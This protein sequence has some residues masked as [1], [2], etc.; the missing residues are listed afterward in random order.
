MSSKDLFSRP[1][2]QQETAPRSLCPKQ[3]IFPFCHAICRL[4]VAVLSRQCIRFRSALFVFYSRSQTEG[5][6]AT[7]G[8]SSRYGSLRTVWKHCPSQ[9]LCL[10]LV[11]C[12]FCPHSTGQSE[13]SG[14]I[15]RLEGG[16][17][18][19]TLNLSREGRD[20]RNLNKKY[21]Q[22]HALEVAA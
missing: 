10:Q 7:E 9:S 11:H 20:R 1:L 13:Y 8:C 18:N 2:L 12:H 15:Y 5:T 17:Y 14:Q 21:F 16:E 6:V 4:A 3:Q 19:L 22:P